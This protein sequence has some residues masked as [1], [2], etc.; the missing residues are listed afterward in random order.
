MLCFLGL[1]SS[2]RGRA[3]QLHAAARKGDGTKDGQNNTAP[4]IIVAS[5]AADP[6]I[7]AAE[8]AEVLDSDGKVLETLLADGCKA[9]D[10]GFIQA[11]NGKAAHRFYDAKRLLRSTE[12]AVL[13]SLCAWRK[14]SHFCHANALSQQWF[15]TSEWRQ[16]KSCTLRPE[17]L[18]HGSQKQPQAPEASLDQSLSLQQCCADIIVKMLSQTEITRK[19]VVPKLGRTLVDVDVFKE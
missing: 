18:E 6:A 8:A 11:M 16:L 3:L 17:I 2:K 12:L 9:L 1:C 10:D 7:A 4:E 15:L 5:G 19:A 13:N 14:R